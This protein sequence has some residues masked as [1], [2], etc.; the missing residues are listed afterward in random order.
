MEPEYNEF[1]VNVRLQSNVGVPIKGTTG[2]PLEAPGSP[3]AGSKNKSFPSMFEERYHKLWL[4]GDRSASVPNY[5]SKETKSLPRALWVGIHIWSIARYHPASR[6]LG[7]RRM[8]RT[9]QAPLKKV[10]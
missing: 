4:Q 2:F 6:S 10:G 5:N 3:Q 9:S 1:I 8:I 7:N